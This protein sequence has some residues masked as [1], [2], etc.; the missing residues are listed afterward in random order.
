M[1][2]IKFIRENLE[3]VK[4][5]ALK[6]HI[7]VDLDALVAL[8]DSRRTLLQSLEAKKAEQN[9]FSQQIASADDVTRA[10]L[11]ADMKVVKEDFQKTEEELKP[12]IVEWQK[13]MVQVPNIPDFSV[14]EGDDDAGNVEVR[15]WGTPPVFDF[16]VKAHVDLMLSTGM[17]DFERGT[18]VAGFRGYFL[19]GDGARLL[20]A[21]TRFVEDRFLAVERGEHQLPWLEGLDV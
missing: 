11:I 10:K 16:P 13:L 18:K 15:T 5:G 12:V 14:P 8:D 20:W 9:S 2:D 4:A 19:K 6:K 21:L 3:L 17:A 1:L 7:T